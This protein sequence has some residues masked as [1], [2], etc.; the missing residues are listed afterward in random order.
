VQIIDAPGYV[1]DMNTVYSFTSGQLEITLDPIIYVT[2]TVYVVDTSGEY[3]EGVTV[4]I[5]NA[6]ETV[7][8]PSQKSDAYGE[9][10]FTVVDGDSWKVQLDGS[11]MYNYFS[12][13]NTVTLRYRGK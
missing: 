10:S 11:S 5:C 12:D 2:Y 3:V 6:D 8:L 13:D 1:F 7:I 4:N 9:V